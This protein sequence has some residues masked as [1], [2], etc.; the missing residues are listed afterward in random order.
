MLPTSRRISSLTQ[1]TDDSHTTSINWNSSRLNYG[2]IES[3]TIRDFKS[4]FGETTIGPF[5][6]FTCIIGPNGSGKSNLM[7]AISFVLGVKTQQLRGKK[8]TDLIHRNSSTSV[9][10]TEAYV[11]LVYISR[12]L[13]TDDAN[14]NREEDEDGSD[15][16]EDHDVDR[17]K[18]TNIYALHSDRFKEE[19]M[20]FRRSITRNGGTINYFNQKRLDF[21]Q[22]EET[23]S[24]IGVIV[25]ARNFLVFQGD[26]TGIAQKTGKQLTKWFEQISGSIAHKQQYDALRIE[27]E[28]I[29]N[30][31]EGV[32]ERNRNLAREK[33]QMKQQKDEAN[34]YKTMQSDLVTLKSEYYRFQLYHIV[35][36]VA[37][38]KDDITAVDGA[39]DAINLSLEE[40]EDEIKLK[41]ADL[42]KT[43]RRKTT[44]GKSMKKLRKSTNAMKLKSDELEKEVI[45]LKGQE[46]K[47]NA[48]NETL[49]EEIETNND[50][51]I[52][53]KQDLDALRDAKDKED[54]TVPTETIEFED[55]QYQIYQRVKKQIGEET[56]SL[57]TEAT[58]LDHIYQRKKD[59][60]ETLDNEHE[61]WTKKKHKLSANRD[62]MQQEMEDLAA[63]MVDI[64]REHETTQK[65]WSNMKEKNGRLAQKREKINGNLQGLLNELKEFEIGIRDNKKELEQYQVLQTLQKLFSGIYGRLCDLVEC[66]QKRFE[67]AVSVALGVN[68]NAVIVEN[69]EI[70]I[71]CM[72][73]M[74][75]TRRG[76]FRFIPLNDI[77]TYSVSQEL[78]RFGGSAQPIIDVIHYETQFE[79]AL[80]F[81][82][83]N[84]IVVETIEEARDI[85]YNNYNKN[86]RTRIRVVSLDGSLISPNGNIC[87]GFNKEFR[88][89]FDLKERNKKMK[90]R[91]EWIEELK[92]IDDQMIGDDDEKSTHELQ[93][94]LN[95]LDNKRRNKDYRWQALDK[96][97]K[98][99]KKALAVL[100]KELKLKA[101]QSKAK[102]KEVLN[103]KRDLNELDQKMMKKEKKI[104]AKYAQ[105]LGVN[106]MREYEEQQLKQ[107]EDR[108][109]KQKIFDVKCIEM[110]NKYKFV[111]NKNVLHM[112]ETK[113]LEK[114]IK[115]MKHDITQLQNKKLNKLRKEIKT[116]IQKLEEKEKENDEIHSETKRKRKM[117]SDKKKEIDAKRK[118]ISDKMKEK[119][120]LNGWIAKLEGTQTNILGQ[121]K[122]EHIQLKKKKKKK[123][124][125]KRMAHRRKRRK[126]NDGNSSDQ[127]TEEDSDSI[128]LSQFENAMDE[129][130]EDEF[131]FESRKKQ[132]LVEIEELRNKIVFLQP[133]MKA[134][135]QYKKLQNKW[136]DGH[137]EHKEMR[138]KVSSINNRVEKYRELRCNQL[139]EC[140][141]II[142]KNIKRIYAE[143]TA[144]R[145]Y[146]N[147]GKAFLNS[148]GA[149]NLFDDEIIFNAMPP[150]KPFRDIQQLSGG[151]KSV[152]S[153]ALLFAIHSY[154]QSPF[155]ILDEIDAALDQKN[156]QRVCN[157]IRKKSM[158]NTQIIVISLKDKFFSNANSLIGVC[159]N[160]RNGDCSMV[161]SIDLT[162]YDENDNNHNI[163]QRRI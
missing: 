98:E 89:R 52:E 14:M 28:Q 48:K 16:D 64:N 152:A 104:F 108:V 70:A 97:L 93:N 136:K 155:F 79:R 37:A 128:D 149:I 47:I 51:L 59:E 33:K 123:K 121:A 45:R 106:S 158:Q 36:D 3:L 78:R 143:L 131:E 160:R 53:L 74:R 138:K 49:N 18:N 94:T 115:Q 6:T 26:V 73:H 100:E 84:T 87:G 17:T 85:A 157:Y 154:K 69:K 101:K 66:R 148:G 161:L 120:K 50:K 15:S 129:D 147:G 124:G 139:T 151:E 95:D 135:E 35:N 91:N 61:I 58:R 150:G 54:Q 82:L 92:A 46:K 83:S 76:H 13:Q 140:F 19:R 10:A 125:K 156:V 90:I 34:S 60:L 96:Q 67:L 12:V 40:C 4:Y 86:N 65:Q 109:Q 112:K 118:E 20:V 56:A 117:V 88:V 21:K 22:Y 75:K 55:N 105:E 80:Q 159:K 9:V 145:Q 27:Q 99:K 119:S 133:N 32:N 43:L 110:E 57:N 29:Q 7:D 25:R 144:S 113:T 153:L 31:F 38:A 146:K 137:V 122:H 103:A 44:I 41:Q 134:L 126:K 111:E 42:G 63:E 114:R 8:L 30:E 71:Q 132:Y 116:K 141:E 72:Q 62:K 39:M 5:S 130:N 127:E 107:I 1:S 24:T 163:P 68:N 162:K 2:Y 81:A 11:E 77:K 142:Q 102:T 23:L